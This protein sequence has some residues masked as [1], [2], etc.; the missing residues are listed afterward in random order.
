MKLYYAAGACSLA[1]HITLREI[2]DDF[3]LVRVDLQSKKTEDDKDFNDINPKGYVPV[4]ELEQGEFLT[5]APAVLQYLAD[6]RPE[7]G[8]APKAGTLKRARL[9]EW[10]NFIGTEL[11][12]PFGTL[13]HPPGEEAKQAAVSQLKRRFAYVADQLNDRA[14]LLGDDF[15][16]ADAYLFAVMRWAPAFE[17]DLAPWPALQDYYQRIAARPTVRK[18]MSVE[19]LDKP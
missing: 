12:K 8:L 17:I 16:V 13:F 6:L 2:G 18:A 9:Q 11:H 7:T 14:Y 19:G 15:S 5:E 4:L 3:E 1:P 10:L